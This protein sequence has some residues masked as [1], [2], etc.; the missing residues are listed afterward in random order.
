M[1]CPRGLV[2]LFVIP[3]LAV[4]AGCGSDRSATASQTPPEAPKPR[5][6]KVVQ[7][8]EVALPRTVVVTGTLAADDQ[9]VLS[10]KVPGRISQITVDL[11]SR[12]K[13]GDVI[14]RLDP[15]DARL[16]LEQAQAGLQQARVRLGLPAD[17]R[18]DAVDPERT[19]LV[20]QARA[21]LDEARLTRE[22]MDQLWERE[23][24]A[25]AQLDTAVAA[26]QVAEGRYQ[27]AIEE[28]RTRQAAIPQRRAE[29]DQARQALADSVL[30]SPADGA[31]R[32]RRASVGQYVEAGAA[33]V[34]LVR[35]HPLRLRVAVPE[36]E[37]VSVRIGQPVRVTVEGDPAT[38]NGRVVRLSPTIEEQQRTLMVEAEI[39]NEQGKLRPG[40]FA[41]SE[42]VAGADDR[43]ILVPAT[44][45]VTF[46]GIEKVLSIADGKAVEKRVLTGRRVDGRV[47]ITQGLK[48]GDPVVVQ[49]GNLVGGQ[50]VTVQ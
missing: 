11:G 31:I 2:L 27:D 18:D 24:I 25:R 19:A 8:A 41:K 40:S 35:M 42:I 23:L 7:A 32:E 10:M 43:A 12:V 20:R 16:R 46:A 13:A 39:G 5:A 1:S 45:I 34:T 28:V 36:R 9:V 50:S 14:A 37:S 30:T 3:A 26:L 22:R 44:S 21:V 4:L 33:V 48:A 29:V 17:G 38:Y 6:V 49:P 15:T 47:E